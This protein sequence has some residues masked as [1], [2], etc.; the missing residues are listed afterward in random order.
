MKSWTSR[1]ATGLGV[2]LAVSAAFV[3]VTGINRPAEKASAATSEVMVSENAIASIYQAASPAVV[4]IQ[5]TTT[6]AGMM[7][8]YQTGGQGSGFVVDKDGNIVTNNHV[9]D[10]ATTVK[11]IFSDGRNV[12]A[13]VA[14]RSAADDVAVVKVDAAAVSTITPLTLT[15][16]SAVKPGYMAIAMG[17]PY[18]LN[19]SISV[20]V[21]SGLSRTVDGSNLSGMLQ[22]DA[23]IQPGNSGGPLLNSSGQVIGVNTAYEGQGT[24]IGF[25]VPSNVV[26][27]LLPDLKAGKQITRPWVGISGMELTQELAGTIG[28]SVNQGVYVV[29]V[30]DSSPA[31][32]AGLKAA[33][34]GANGVPGK[35]GDVITA[36]DGN[37]VK[38]VTD[39]QNYLAQ[40][41]VGDTVALSITRDGSSQS[42]KVTLAARPSD[43]QQATPQQTP[44]TPNLPWQWR[45]R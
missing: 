30:V 7:G 10:G 31:Q 16:S 20:G 6:G 9:V 4:E 28:L 14:G 8:G 33:G 29:T 3:L 44:S 1:I 36:I 25:A 22:T 45:N 34:A 21:I 27:K 39:M 43:T 15:D 19:N 32:T 17:S 12:T 26:T 2:L 13:N 5:V 23:N 42:V 38:S 24:G 35:G 18:G 37:A 11:V 41:K 40:K